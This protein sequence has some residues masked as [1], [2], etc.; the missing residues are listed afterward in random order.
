LATLCQVAR[1]SLLSIERTE[2]PSAEVL[3][4]RRC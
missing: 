3:R 2:K 1:P 4:R